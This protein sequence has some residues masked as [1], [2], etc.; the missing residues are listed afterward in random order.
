MG[1]NH[2]PVIP[3]LKWQPLIDCTQ[4]NIETQVD[5][6]GLNTSGRDQDIHFLACID[7]FSIYLTVEIFD[8]NNGPNVI[9][10]LDEYIQIHGVPRNI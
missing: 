2:K 7:R 1:K 5:F 4:S 6:G 10:L 8:K 3:A 9:K